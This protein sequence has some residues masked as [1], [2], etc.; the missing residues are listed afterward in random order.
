MSIIGQN[1]LAGASSAGGYTIDQSL[2]FNRGDQSYLNWTPGSAGDAR[3]MTVS[4]WVK[5][6][7][8]TGGGVMLEANGTDWDWWGVTGNVYGT[9]A[10][11]RMYLQGGIMCDLITRRLFRDPTNWYHMVLSIDTDQAVSADRIKMYIN[12]VQINEWSTYTMISQNTNI[13][14]FNAAV[15]QRI[16]SSDAGSALEYMAEYYFIDGQQLPAS[17][18][19]ETDELTGEWKPKKFE[20]T[21]GS[22]G[23]YLKFEN[24]AAFGNDS[25]GNDND[26]TPVSLS[27]H[28]Q[29]TDTPTN[30]FCTWNPINGNQSSMSEGMMAA[31]GDTGSS[32]ARGPNGTFGVMTGKWYWEEYITAKGTNSW[33]GAVPASRGRPDETDNEYIDGS[34]WY[35]S[36]GV[37]VLGSGSGSTS[38][39][40]GDTYDTADII[41]VALDLDNDAI[42]FHKN[43]TWQNS[44]VP[45]SGASRTNAAFTDFSGGEDSPLGHFIT[46]F[47]GYGSA[48]VSANFGQDGT[49][50]GV[51]TAQGN[52][53]SSGKGDFYYSV[54]S[55]YNSLCIDNLPEPTI[56]DS[57]TNFDAQ[58]YTGTGASKAITTGFQPDMVWGKQRNGSS[59]NCVMDVVRG[60]S[61]TLK[62]NSDAAVEAASDVITAWDSDG[63]T[64]G[65]SATGPNMNINTNT[66]VAYSW[67]GG[68]TGV[69]NTTGSLNST[70]SANTT[71]GFSVVKFT[72]DNSAASTVGHGLSSAPDMI[73]VK[74]M[75]DSSTDWCVYFNTDNAGNGKALLL[76]TTAIY[77]VATSYWNDTS[78]T[79]SVFSLGTS[80]DTNEN[81]KD[82]IAY[83]FTAVEGF[84]KIGGYVGNGSTSGQV[85]YTGFKPEFVMVKRTDSTS[86]ANWG[87]S[88]A[89]IGGPDN[90]YNTIAHSLAAN[91]ANGESNFG[92]LTSNIQDYGSNYFKFRNGGAYGNADGGTYLYIA[93]AQRPYNYSRSQ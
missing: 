41:G 58:R 25:S 21:Y 55:G 35:R 70:V 66:F 84:C 79:A 89:A 71:S 50:A 67:K 19:A 82:H 18:F 48:A 11:M 93:M 24:S 73:L 63:F 3:Q 51:K 17:D 64:L 4:L 36:T 57:N 14:N 29:M 74:Q 59:S 88:V 56:K 28:D 30:N 37:K 7:S 38:T 78:P 91:E 72:G 13:Y 81:T 45:T 40:Y 27:A 92:G 5:G 2:R 39:A 53:D 8:E 10:T 43:G 75:T 90:V 20:G 1:I 85:I 31:V 26:F 61:S 46:G 87:T 86:S 16:Q 49:F 54:P 34:I 44:G 15:N 65:T 83:C 60:L 9:S 22:N 6:P 32:Y 42:Y 33:V 77:S 69:A 80:N 62:T 68:G 76:N 23:Y 47:C 12:G 52:A